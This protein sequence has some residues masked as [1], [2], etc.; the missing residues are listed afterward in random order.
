MTAKTTVGWPQLAALLLVAWGLLV[1]RIDAPYHEFHNANG[2]WISASIRNFRE[3]GMPALGYLPTREAGPTS[4]ETYEPYFNHPPMPVWL[5]G[6]MSLAGGLNEVSVRFVFVS[7]TLLSVVGLYVLT[8]RLYD[9]RIAWW[10]CVIYLI[11]PLTTYFGR[12]PDWFLMSLAA[13]VLYAAVFVNWLRRPTW[14]RFTGMAALAVFGVYTFWVMILYVGL[15]GLLALLIGSNRH[16]LQTMLMGGVGVLAVGSMLGLYSLGVSGFFSQMTDIFLWRAGG[17]TEENM[18][19]LPDLCALADSP[20]C[21]ATLSTFTWLEFWQDFFYDFISTMTP[22]IF[23]LAVVGIPVAWR[24]GNAQT[25]WIVGTLYG[26][27]LVWVLLLRN[28]NYT[29][30]FYSI[31][32]FVPAAITAATVMPFALRR[33]PAPAFTR[34]ARAFVVALVVTGAANGLF[35]YLQYHS[36]GT[37]PHMVLNERVVYHGETINTLADLTREDDFIMT[38]VE[39]LYEF[40]AMEYYAYRDVKWGYQPEDALQYAAEAGRPTSYMFCAPDATV[41]DGFADFPVAT[42]E[43]SCLVF[44]MAG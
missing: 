15:L 23:L 26:V 31:Y 3:Y 5:P 17:I 30:H 20:R 8:R 32:L 44:R 28:A 4:P 34:L 19:R 21:E 1:Y 27:V 16:R 18:S 7:A 14:A 42:G 25:R 33:T 38:N 29:H 40:M 36:S 35:L 10:A 37:L 39:F 41:P 43:N 13:G 9:A 12:S 22:G 24:M 11:M 2:A 6:V